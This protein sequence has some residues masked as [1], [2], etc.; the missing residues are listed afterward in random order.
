M[1]S[2]ACLLLGKASLQLN[3]AGGPL[4]R[5]L[6][7]CCQC[8]DTSNFISYEGDGGVPQPRL[9]GVR[10]VKHSIAGI[11]LVLPGSKYTLLTTHS[12]HTAAA[13][14]PV[15]LHAQQREGVQ[16]DGETYISLLL[17]L[18]PRPLR[19]PSGSG[20]L[21]LLAEVPGRQLLPGAAALHH[22]CVKQSWMI[23]AA[24]ET[25]WLVQSQAFGRNCAGTASWQLKQVMPVKIRQLISL[26]SECVNTLYCHGGLAVLRGFARCVL[27]ALQHR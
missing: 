15:S 12:K 8:D 1:E 16:F 9:S 26:Q 19:L 21:P 22:W 5:L 25:A 11:K 3:P 13:A 4:S 20:L 17:Q 27:P 23:Q 24:S 18:L 6:A 7:C 2:P 14:T 10:L